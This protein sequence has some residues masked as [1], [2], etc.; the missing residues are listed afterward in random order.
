MNKDCLQIRNVMVHVWVISFFIT[1]CEIHFSG[2]IE[3]LD[4][5]EILC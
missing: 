1:V 2:F 4:S 3:A 5:K